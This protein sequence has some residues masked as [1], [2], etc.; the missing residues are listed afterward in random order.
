MASLSGAQPGAGGGENDGQGVAGPVGLAFLEIAVHLGHLVGDMGEAQNR[1]LTGGGEG[2]KRGRF[3]LDSEEA[4]GAHGFD[5]LRRFPERRI[6][7]PDGAALHRLTDPGEGTCHSRDQRAVGMAEFRRRQIVVT[8]ALVAQ[9]P[10]D[11]DEVGGGRSAAMP[12]S[13]PSSVPR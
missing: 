6:G 7:G 2:I 4:A 1:L 5:R 3:H 11:Q 13:I 8:G 10:V 9:C 12:S